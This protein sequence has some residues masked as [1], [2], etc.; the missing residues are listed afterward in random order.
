MNFIYDILDSAPWPFLPGSSEEPPTSILSDVHISGGF[1]SAEL[2][3][4]TLERRRLTAVF[5]LK[6]YLG[7]VETIVEVT[8]SATSVMPDTAYPIVD[9]DGRVWGR[10]VTGQILVDRGTLRY[11]DMPLDP[12]TILSIGDADWLTPEDASVEDRYTFFGDNG[13]VLRLDPITNIVWLS[14]DAGS[15]SF[16]SNPAEEVSIRIDQDTGVEAIGSAKGSNIYLV[17]EG[18]TLEI[19]P[20][21]VGTYAHT[22]AITFVYSA[23]VDPWS[24]CNG[25]TVYE[26]NIKCSSKEGS[27]TPYP[28]DEYFCTEDVSHCRYEWETN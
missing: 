20:A 24:G 4:I 15:Y 22:N 7:A 2:T 27:S 26:D 10:I 21:T 28:L 19:D 13:V 11:A 3:Q 5:L 25:T 8:A 1:I 14:V 17:I 6:Y 12:R 16:V 9:Q 18:L 23:A